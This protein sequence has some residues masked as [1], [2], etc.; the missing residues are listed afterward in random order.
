MIHKITRLENVNGK[1][2]FRWEPSGETTPISPSKWDDIMKQVEKMK[3]W[4]E[5]I[6][7]T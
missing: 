7:E 4:E 3:I 6:F 2:S 5:K 1:I